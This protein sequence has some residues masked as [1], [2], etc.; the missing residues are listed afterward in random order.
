MSY[1]LTQA[2]NISQKL[3]SYNQLR[4]N[5]YITKQRQKI[6]GSIYTLIMNSISKCKMYGQHIFC[7]IISQYLYYVPAVVTRGLVVV[8]ACC[9]SVVVVPSVVQF[10]HALQQFLCI[11]TLFFMHSWSRAQPVHCTSSHVFLHS[12]NKHVMINY[13]VRCSALLLLPS[14]WFCQFVCAYV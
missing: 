9:L 5:L 7:K 1:N 12:G 6:K 11:Q 10:L 13:C 3:I 14:R 4:Y 8:C 2:T